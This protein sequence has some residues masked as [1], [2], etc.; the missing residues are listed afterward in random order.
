[1]DEL[2]KLIREVPD[3][4]KPGILFYDITTVLKDKSGF[5][6]IIEALTEQIRPYGAD[7]VLGI[8]ARGFIFAPALAYNLGGGVHSGTEAQETARRDRTNQLR[9]RIWRRHARN[10]QETLSS[11]VRESSLRM[12]CWQPVERAL[13]Y[14]SSCGKARRKRCRGELRHRVGSLKGLATA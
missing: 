10:P 6:R 1:M 2:K 5:R 13:A 12:T 7:A 4:P 11:L 9:T 14:R 3:F 8:E